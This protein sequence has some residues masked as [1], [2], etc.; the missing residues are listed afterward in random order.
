MKESTKRTVRTVVQMLLGFITAVP[1][2]LLLV[3]DGTP[4][5]AQVAGVLAWCAA[6]TKGWNVLEDAGVIPAWLKTEA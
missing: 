2:L 3:P 1:V 6:I 4:M 5:P